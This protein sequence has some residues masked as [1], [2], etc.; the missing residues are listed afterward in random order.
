MGYKL[1]WF[2]F[3]LATCSSIKP[4]PVVAIRQYVLGA[5]GEGIQINQHLGEAIIFQIWEKTEK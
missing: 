1:N 2:R 5:T 3:D 4:M